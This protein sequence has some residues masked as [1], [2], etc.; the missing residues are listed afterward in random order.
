MKA[1]RISLFV[2]LG[3]VLILAAGAAIFVATFDANRYKPE[4]E[5]LVLDRTGRTLEIE[6]DVN[7]S[8]FPNIGADLGKTT[9]SD[10]DPSQ[11]FVT[12]ESTR[13][14]VALMPLISG[15]VLV[16]GLVIDGLSAN[17]TRDEDGDFNFA[18]LLITDVSENDAT[19]PS[20][21]EPGPESSAVADEPLE[22]DIGSI[23]ISNA[24]LTYLDSQNGVDLKLS[25]LNLETGQIA[26]KAEG[27]LTFSADAKSKSLALDN[28]IAVNG[29]Y[30]LNLAEQQIEWSGLEIKLN[31]DWQD[32]KS[33]NAVLSLALI[34]NLK[35][36]TYVASDI[37][38]TVKAQMAGETIDLQANTAKATVTDNTV[39][40]EPAQLKLA[41]KGKS[42][43]IATELKLPAFQFANDT[44]NLKA[45]SV[46]VEVTD[47]AL[48]NDSLNVTTQ[49]DLS[50]NTANERLN[51]DLTGQFDGAPGKAT[52][53]ISGFTEPA[54]TFDI[55]LAQLNL[56]RFGT[57]P[58]AADSDSSANTG[59]GSN[60]ASNADSSSDTPIDLSVLKGHNV[61]GKVQVGKV[62]GKS[63]GKGLSIDQV[64][65]DVVLNQGRLTVGP[66]SA[67]L[68]DGKLSG[69]LT[70]D[71]NNQQF[72]VKESISGINLERVLVALGQTP[73]VTGN[74][75]VSI[76]LATTGQSVASLKQNLSGNANVSLQ[77]GVV[78]GIDVGA[79]LNNVR[80]M[81]GKAPTQQ[82]DAS[83]QTTFTELKAS[84]NIQKGIAT[85]NDLSIKAPLFRL[86][87]S[88]TVNIPES[89]LDYL[90]K[91]AVV[92]TS[93]GQGGADLAAL[94]GVTIP[95]K[96]TGTFENPKYRVDVASLAAELA[97][98]R[99][100]DK[101]QEE[102]NRAVPGLGDALKGLF[103]R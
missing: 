33:M 46:N 80:A 60:S 6:G 76:D 16:D 12:I 42:R 30:N 66:H 79:I 63:L 89:S 10:K 22:L 95:I 37:S 92:E 8:L 85:N 14:S 41:T 98:S 21:T 23:T 4:I 99:L 87:G 57:S 97:K 74:G 65:T 70:I 34:G 103:G 35:N 75:A 1:L 73:R 67:Q 39:S 36:S 40:V 31:G 72:L 5:Q 82:G 50:L 45:L 100:G 18:D 32:L 44:L 68:F 51:T 69:S 49:G 94:R 25:D 54:I 13:V 56:D 17:V 7:L 19:E 48:G 24:N 53:A 38:G 71:S 9:L 101:A 64:Q 52:I 15:Q 83:G 77:D 78:K 2:V 96:I 27:K 11:A 62:V 102:I 90:A 81:L 20:A 88:G 91:V 43:S 55:N 86:L 28:Q 93:T 47:A 3:V 84:A 59:S 29:D 58:A 61:K 26:E